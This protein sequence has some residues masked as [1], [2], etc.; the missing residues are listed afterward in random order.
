MR[1]LGWRR[2]LRRA[3]VVDRRR[4]LDQVQLPR[5]SLTFP[6]SQTNRDRQRSNTTIHRVD[7]NIANMNR[8]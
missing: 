2:C 1:R 6:D 4:W 7:L 8:R 3:R 5:Q